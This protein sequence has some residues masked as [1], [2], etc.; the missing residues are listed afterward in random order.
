M[1]R[2]HPFGSRFVALIIDSIIFIPLAIINYGVNTLD[3]PPVLSHLWLLVM[4]LA[5]PFYTIVMHGLYGQTLGKMAVKIK[6]VDL[7]ENPITFHHAVLRSLPQIFFSLILIFLSKPQ[8]TDAD[9]ILHSATAT[10]ASIMMFAALA[11]NLADIAV[12]FVNHKRR[13]LHDFVAGT[14]VIEM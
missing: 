12:F 14:V 9:G 2:H 6:V 3:L 8:T 13:A 7:Y 1:E 4:T 11:W 10:F 5:Q